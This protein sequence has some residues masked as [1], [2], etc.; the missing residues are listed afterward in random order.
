MS[1]ADLWLG[2]PV[3]PN[4]SIDDLVLRYLAAYGPASVADAQ[5]W[6]GL[7]RLTEVFDRLELRTYTD[8][9]SGRTLYDLPNT[10]LP[11]EDLDVPTRF[12]PEYDNLLLSHANRTRWL[13]TPNLLQQVFTQ[14][15]LLHKGQVTAS[16]K[17]TREG[18]KSAT[19]R[20]EPLSQLPKKTQAALEPEAQ[21][22]LQFA[23]PNVTHDIKF[24][25]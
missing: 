23:A 17:L 8:A 2:S 5:S 18:T 14:G 16:W 3:D 13:A 15:A 24:I 1:T 20:I 11:D 25:L 19:L 4:P 21:A 9:E 12:L 22:L 10:V 6:S 7:T